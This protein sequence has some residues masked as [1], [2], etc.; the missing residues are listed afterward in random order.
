[1]WENVSNNIIGIKLKATSTFFALLIFANAE[2][3]AAPRFEDFPAP[4]YTGQR[5]GVHLQ[6]AKS[7]MYASRLR[8][9]SHDAINF[10]GRH[11]LATWGCGTSCFVGAAIDAQTGSVTWLPGT[12]C[13]WDHEITEPLAYRRDSHL[14][15][16]H[17]RL[18]EQGAASDVHYY[19][20]DGKRFIPVSPAP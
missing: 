19:D 8:L 7:R 12:V 15:V 18:D 9:A 14:L 10:S 16:V 4:I 5:A 2:V 17:G 20:F 11:V 13:C 1:M 3:S 6:G